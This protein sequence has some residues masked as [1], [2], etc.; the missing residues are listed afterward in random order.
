MIPMKFGGQG[1]N[2]P[3]QRSR[4]DFIKQTLASDNKLNGDG[5]MTA[6]YNMLFLL[7]TRVTKSITGEQ[8]DDELFRSYFIRLFRS[9]R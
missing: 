8:M 9:V 4:K 3:V 1:E 5:Y 6:I 2:Q 7:Q